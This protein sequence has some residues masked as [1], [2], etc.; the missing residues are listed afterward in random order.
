MGRFEVRY[1]WMRGP[2]IEPCFFHPH[3]MPLELV[4]VTA[5]SFSIPR[6]IG[7][8]FSDLESHRISYMSSRFKAVQVSGTRRGQDL[9]PLLLTGMRSERLASSPSASLVSG[10][11]SLTAT[12]WRS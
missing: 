2:V 3:K 9:Q 7:L 5:S 8:T 10:A 12:L 4:G 1:R 6:A 11:K